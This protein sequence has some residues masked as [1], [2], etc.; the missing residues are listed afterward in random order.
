[1][2]TKC[3]PYIVYKAEKTDKKDIM[4]FYKSQRY[5]ARY[6]GQDQGYFIK[7]NDNI[8]A[9]VIVSGGR[10]CSQ[11]WLLHALV[12]R[13]TYRKKGIASLLLRTILTENSSSA[14]RAI[15]QSKAKVASYAN[16]ICFAAPNLQALYVSNQFVH[17]NSPDDIAQLPNEFRS[18]F[19]R[20]QEKHP[21][22]CCYCYSA[23]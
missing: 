4:R 1:M 22:L 17:Y 10:E 9:C 18:R 3:P 2:P 11:F 5:S 12:I 6:I 15:E 8:I 20:Y 16:I 23:S 19:T 13:P 14:I 21:S 7:I